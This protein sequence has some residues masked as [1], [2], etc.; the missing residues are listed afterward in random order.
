MISELK[1]DVTGRKLADLFSFALESGI[2]FERV[3]AL[4]EKSF[5]ILATV[6][7]DGGFM[8]ADEVFRE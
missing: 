5:V 6:E 8:N 3:E 7:D 2:F 4:G 1:V